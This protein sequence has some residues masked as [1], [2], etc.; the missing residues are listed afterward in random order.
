MGGF[1]AISTCEGFCC[2][3]DML[4]LKTHQFSRDRFVKLNFNQDQQNLVPETPGASTALIVALSCWKLEAA[5][6]RASAEP[7]H[8]RRSPCL[9]HC[10]DDI[11]RH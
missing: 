4:T 1:R 11:K 9:R 10:V 2:L 6:T 7:L 3:S 5:V 8:L